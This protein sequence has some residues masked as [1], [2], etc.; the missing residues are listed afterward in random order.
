MQLGKRE[1]VFFV[2]RGHVAQDVLFSVGGH[3]V[4]FF[5]D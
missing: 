4:F 1:R 5:H 3:S 2:Q